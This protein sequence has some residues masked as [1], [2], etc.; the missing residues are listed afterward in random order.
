MKTANA[1]ERFED[2]DNALVPK[3]SLIRE[4][5]GGLEL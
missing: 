2:I 5:I 3:D 4:F 1:L